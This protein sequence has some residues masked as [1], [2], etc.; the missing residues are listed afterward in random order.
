M[1]APTPE[2]ARNQTTMELRGDREIVIARTFNGPARTVFDAWTRADLVRRWWAPRSLGVSLVSCDA[3]VRVGGGYR[4]VLQARE[5]EPFA[6]SGRYTEVT[7]STRLVY[8][9]V[10]EPM[11]DAGEAVI[12]VTFEEDGGRTH[13]VSRERYP[14]PQA[15]DGAIASGMEVGMRETMDQLDELVES[16]S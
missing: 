3:D 5:G 13:M 10:F 7:P 1:A 14:S 16:L 4:Y 2:A 11:A 8:T 15:R 12:T 6:F 9:Q